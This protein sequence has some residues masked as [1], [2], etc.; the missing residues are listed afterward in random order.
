MKPLSLLI[1][2]ASIGP[3]LAAPQLTTIYSFKGDADGEDPNAVTVGADG[4]LYGTTSGG[5]TKYDE[6]TIFKLS[7]PAV[8]G[9]AWT[10]E[11]LY[12]FKSS[13]SGRVYSGVTLDMDTGALLGAASG[14][15]GRLHMGAIFRLVP[16]PG[17]SG[18]WTY[19]VI[20][21]FTGG[22]DGE[23]PYQRLMQD[24]ATGTIYGSTQGNLSDEAS[25]GTV[26]AFAPDAAHKH[27][28]RTLNHVFTGADGSRPGGVAI[29]PNGILYGSASDGGAG[30]GTIF[31]LDPATAILTTLFEPQS[32][33]E[34]YIFQGVPV[35]SD[36]GSTMYDTSS[37]GD[38]T[39]CDIDHLFECGAVVSMPVDGSAAPS[40]LQKF[41]A[42]K[43]ADSVS[44]LVWNKAHTAL[45]G[46]ALLGLPN[47]CKYEGRKFGCGTVFK[48]FRKNGNWK[49]RLI[50]AFDGTDGQN[51]RELTLGR[52]GALYGTTA[53]GGS[54]KAGT[55]FRIDP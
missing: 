19:T 20:H 3:A 53:N 36:D 11:T 16:P 50:Y 41:V 30:F 13:Q 55:V 39:R 6:G 52:D 31:S 34:R 7:P 45:Y 25:L 18:A 8:P 51:P 21:D 40:V 27:W 49:Y 17:G 10:K 22:S 38:Q 43:T 42:K 33:A 54:S 2:L 14:Q 28:T 26:F 32:K 44:G 4:T 46:S 29:G 47:I 1:L 23:F 9:E 35:F 37:S 12:T 48:L 5:G 24:P 15:E